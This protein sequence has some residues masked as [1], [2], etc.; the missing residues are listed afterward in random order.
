MDFP[1]STEILIAA[2]QVGID[3]SWKSFL[4]WNVAFGRQFL[5]CELSILLPS[6]KYPSWEKG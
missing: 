2:E 4:R 3:C 6:Q 1:R 5:I